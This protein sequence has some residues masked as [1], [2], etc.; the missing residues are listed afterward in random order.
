MTVVLCANRRYR[1]LRTE[2]ARARYRPA[3]PQAAGPQRSHPPGD[4]LGWAGQGFGLPACSVDVDTDG[5]FVG[6][7]EA[8]I[9]NAQKGNEFFIMS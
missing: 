2:I 8:H 4:R 5:E 1:I 3:G 9:K 7:V 6:T